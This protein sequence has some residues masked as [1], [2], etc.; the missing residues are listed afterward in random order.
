MMRGKNEV[1]RIMWVLGKDKP[2]EAEESV[3]GNRAIVDEYLF[4]ICKR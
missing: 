3:V 4:K 1:V 2:V